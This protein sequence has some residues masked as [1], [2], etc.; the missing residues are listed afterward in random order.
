MSTQ[1]KDP[2]KEFTKRVIGNKKTEETP[3][4]G[5]EKSDPIQKWNEKVLGTERAKQ[6]GKLG[7][8]GIGDTAM[9]TTTT[10]TSPRATGK[11][12]PP[13]MSSVTEFAVGKKRAKTVAGATS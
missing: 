13:T 10:T 1:K 9:G 5:T 12:S 8:L 3:A 2:Y 6:L 4:E 11:Y 7:K